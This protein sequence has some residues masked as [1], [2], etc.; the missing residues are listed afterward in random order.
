M[1]DVITEAAEAFGYPVHERRGLIRV[2]RICSPISILFEEAADGRTFM[3]LGCQAPRFWN[4]DRTDL[5]DVFSWLIGAF[6]RRIKAASCQFIPIEHP[7]AEVPGE[8]YGR[9]LML[10]QSSGYFLR[11]NKEG[12]ESVWHTLMYCAMFEQNAYEKYTFWHPETPSRDLL[13]DNA[14]VRGWADRVANAIGPEFASDEDVYG[15]RLSTNWYYYRTADEQISVVESSGLAEAIRGFLPDGEDSFL[16]VNGLLYTDQEIS[17]F[18]P[19][20]DVLLAHSI[21]DGMGYR[22]SDEPHANGSMAGIPMENISVFTR[23]NGVVALVGRYGIDEFKSERA[24]LLERNKREQARLFPPSGFEWEAKI[25]GARFEQLI[26]EL[27]CLEP[28]VAEVR[29]V[30]ATRERDGGRDLI[31]RWATPVPSGEV[32]TEDRVPRRER[33]IIVQCKVRQKSVGR[34]DLG[35]GVLDTLYM[36]KADGYF[37]AVSTQL[38]ASAIDLLDEMRSRGDYFTGWWGRLEIEQR[39]RKHPEIVKQFRDVVRA[40]GQP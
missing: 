31:A 29:T 39:L 2:G 32:G 24:V 3:C 12:K 9:Y 21:L 26:Y 8:L 7:A 37:M 25:D 1:R 28:G 38:A 10:G 11:N 13:F 27:I 30:G 40:V 33:K 16:A 17:N 15:R 14:D 6:M 19:R 18:I 4:Q 34:G 20:E 22:E 23:G 35:Q 36:Y 5:N